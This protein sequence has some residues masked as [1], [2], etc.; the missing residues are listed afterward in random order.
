MDTE[1][2]AML[3]ERD[4]EIKELRIRLYASEYQQTLLR[5]ALEFSLDGTKRTVTISRRVGES[6]RQARN[7]INGFVKD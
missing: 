1:Y 4:T 5:E 2:E 7:R 6:P 3:M